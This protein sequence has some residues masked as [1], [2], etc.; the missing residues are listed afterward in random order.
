MQE[1]SPHFQLPLEEIG[2]GFSF[3]RL[4]FSNFKREIP[5]DDIYEK[6][7]RNLP[8]GRL[9]GIRKLSFLSHIGPNSEKTVF[10]QFNHN[11]LDH[12]TLVAFLDKEILMKNGFP[13]EQIAV[14]FLTGLTHDIGTPAFGDVAKKLDLQALDEEKFWW[15]TLGQEGQDFITR[16]LGMSQKELN[17]IINNKGILGQVLDIADR[18]A[19]TM[20]DLAAVIEPIESYEPELGP[21]VLSLRHLATLDQKIGDIYKEVGIDRRK[22]KVFFNDPHRLNRF[23]LIRANLYK[24]LYVNPISQGRDLLAAKLLSPLYSRSK[25]SQLNPERL[26]SIDDNQLIILEMAKSLPKLFGK[27]MCYPEIYYTLLNTLINWY[28]KYE[29]FDDFFNA[30]KRTQ[31]LSKNK[32]IA[33]IGINECPGFDSGTSYN[34]ATPEGEIVPFNKFM[35]EEASQ[36]EQIAES[37]KGFFVLYENVSEDSR[38]NDLLKRVLKPRR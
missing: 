25:T 26:R 17:D 9:H 3:V 4:P 2:E 21:Y 28:P 37:T 6:A 16:Q 27:T 19:Y 1:R 24:Y 20:I 14:G 35:P 12:S 7:L 38:I 22:D 10:L 31:K 34:I 18:I 32:N 29:K 33:V 30:T 23:L 5:E 36:I 8:L 15:E 11:T 13:E